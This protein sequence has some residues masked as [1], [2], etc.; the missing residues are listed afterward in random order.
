M[1]IHFNKEKEISNTGIGI[2][3]ALT[4]PIPILYKETKITKDTMKA[5]KNTNRK[6]S[7]E[8]MIASFFNS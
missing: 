8:E 5:I 3:H 1:I 4:T 2:I 6:E 7:K